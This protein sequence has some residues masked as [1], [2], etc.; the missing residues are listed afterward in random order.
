M[1]RFIDIHQHSAFGV[2]DGADDSDHAKRMLR[3]SAADN[4]GCV[5]ATS[6][7]TPG[8]VPF[9]YEKYFAAV[10]EMNAYSASEGLGITVCTGC[11]VLYTDATRRFLDEQQ[12][13]PL[14]S[15][16]AVLIEFGQDRSADYI[17]EALR[18]V[19]SAGYRPVLAHAERYLSLLNAP[20][21]ILDLKE[22]LRVLIQLNTGAILRKRSILSS[23]DRKEK[24]FF[25]YVLENRLAD[26]VA[27]DAHNTSSRKT[28][29]TECYNFLSAEYGTDYA[30]RLTGGNIGL[31]SE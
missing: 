24:R 17:F 8:V 12:I 27:T 29:M 3:A 5:F 22:E 18:Q 21:S 28:R 31:L 23:W 25:K 9:P 1:T 26:F 19:A 4:V 15:A 16:K 20:E 14:G 2:D 13:L 10:N 7:M 6:H 11:E 30:D